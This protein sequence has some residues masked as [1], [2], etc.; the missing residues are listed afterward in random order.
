VLAYPGA[1]PSLRLKALRR[2]LEDRL[3]LR[4]LERCGGTEA[5][6]RLIDR[7]VPKALGEAGR[8][9]SWPVAEADWEDARNE[10][11]NDVEAACRD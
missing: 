2:G 11:L 6:K 7:M 8:R 10:L 9:A 5:A 1:R 3:L 4:E